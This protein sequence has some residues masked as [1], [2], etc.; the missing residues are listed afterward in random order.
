MSIYKI[1]P[2][3]F[4][5]AAV[6]SL[7]VSSHTTGKSPVV[8]TFKDLPLSAS[9]NL[10]SVCSTSFTGVSSNDRH[11]FVSTGQMLFVVDATDQYKPRMVR[12][13]RLPA[14]VLSL[15]A[16]HDRLYA[17]SSESIFIY[18]VK[19]FT[20]PSL[21]ATFSPSFVNAPIT[22]TR[23]LKQL[24]GVHERRVWLF[25]HAQ[26][27]SPL[28]FVDFGQIQAINSSVAA[29]P[30]VEFAGL[31][32]AADPWHWITNAHFKSPNLFLVRMD[33]H[34]G[35]TTTTLL[36]HPVVPTVSTK[37]A[38]SLMVGR[39]AGSFSLQ[40]SDRFIFESGHPLDKALGPFDGF[41]IF[42]IADQAHPITRGHLDDLPSLVAANGDSVLALDGN[43]MTLIDVRNP[44]VPRIRGRFEL[45]FSPRA[46]EM[47]GTR[48]Y[49]VEDASAILRLHVF[50]LSDPNRLKLQ[51][52][53]SF[54]CPKAEVFVPV[55]AR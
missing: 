48:A 37:P 53:A 2:L 21:A 5:A 29:Q 1:K 18:D 26:S 25:L 44:D 27:Q 32:G 50:D 36:I 31:I 55:T 51:G 8:A 39:R 47:E 6:M 20:Q 9:S 12:M 40:F 23:V 35:N 30:Q 42:D 11:V 16:D 34:V 24:L 10:P 49:V 7:V 19:D 43:S 15:R 46:V 54:W 45:P 4:S 3:L 13:L 41:A 17:A 14:E 38:A 33:H 28:G 22:G 52:T